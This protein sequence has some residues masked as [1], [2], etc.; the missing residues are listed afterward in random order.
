MSAEEKREKARL[1]KLGE[2]KKISDF[3]LASESKLK[4]ARLKVGEKAGEEAVLAEYDK[5]GGLILKEVAGEYQV[6]ETGTFYDFDKKA[7]KFMLKKTETKE[8]VETKPKAA[9]TK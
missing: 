2:L 8:V 3:T 4:R 9:K 7:P 1:K 6:V 5:H